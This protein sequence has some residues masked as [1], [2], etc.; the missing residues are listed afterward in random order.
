MNRVLVPTP[1][2]NEA[3]S[4]PARAVLDRP[5]VAAP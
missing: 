5:G 1:A 2:H 4:L 3:A